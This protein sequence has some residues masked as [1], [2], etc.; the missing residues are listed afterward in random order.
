[1]LSGELLRRLQVAVD[2]ERAR[3][4]ERREQLEVDEP[5]KRDGIGGKPGPLPEPT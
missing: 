4:A 5:R 2:A 1:V 3:A